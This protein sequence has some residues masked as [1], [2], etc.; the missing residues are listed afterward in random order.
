MW[1]QICS[2]SKHSKKN[3]LCGHRFKGKFN[4]AIEKFP[5]LFQSS[6]WPHRRGF[7]ESLWIVYKW[8][9]S[10]STFTQCQ[11]A[12]VEYKF[13]MIQLVFNFLD[14]NKRK[15]HFFGQNV[16]LSNVYCS[17]NAL[18]LVKNLTPG[19]PGAPKKAEYRN[20]HVN[21]CSKYHN[22]AC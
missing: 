21:F 8:P 19:V 11:G 3:I 12:I 15:R 2:S 18:L 7:R 9:S 1:S 20:R 16:L 10:Q 17:Q 14:I 22:L 4:L 13:S 5:E 6:F